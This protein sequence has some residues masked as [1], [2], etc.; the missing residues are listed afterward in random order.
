MVAITCVL[1]F[2]IVLSLLLPWTLRRVAKIYDLDLTCGRPDLSLFSSD[3]GLWHV[4]VTQHGQPVANVDYCRAD[5]SI[6]NL[7]RGRLVVQRLEADGVNLTVQ[8]NADGGIPL[9]KG[10]LMAGPQPGAAPPPKTTNGKPTPIDLRPP[11]AIDALRLTHVKT[12]LIDKAVSPALDTEVQM[13][14]RLSDLASPER[15]VKFSMEL[16]PSAKNSPLLDSVVVEAENK[17]VSDS[18]SLDATFHASAF[19]LHPKMLEGYLSPLGLHVVANGLTLHGDG[20]IAIS[21]IPTNPNSVTGSI[22][23]T[24][25]AIAAD[26]QEA[27]VV[28]SISIALDSLGAGRLPSEKS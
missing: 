24:D 18:K 15:P 1:L 9:L 21:V 20:N 5:I 3:A 23:L 27:A 11:V 14:L 28:H 2:Q 12:H 19:G 26:A 7:F 4:N 16:L 8:R 6:L 10:L 25:L 13:N 17:K 22:D